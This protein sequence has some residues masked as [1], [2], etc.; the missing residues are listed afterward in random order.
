MELDDCIMTYFMFK[1]H[2]GIQISIENKN[3]YYQ[4]ANKGIRNVDF[5]D[6]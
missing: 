3:K 1:E 5:A 6:T 4:R 2:Y